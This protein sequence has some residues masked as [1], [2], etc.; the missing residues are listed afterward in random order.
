VLA[1]VASGPLA[2]DTT[3]LVARMRK[4]RSARVLVLAQEPLPEADHL[5]FPDTLPEWL[6][7]LVDIIP[8]QLFTAAL[9]RAKGLDVE[10]PRGL[11]KVT[12][13]S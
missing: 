9:A 11:K 8:A 7:P 5:P 6:S 3:E 1:V 2:V 10:R 4:E 12:R 13:T